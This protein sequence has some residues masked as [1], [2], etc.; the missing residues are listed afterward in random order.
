MGGLCEWGLFVCSLCEDLVL[1]PCSPSLGVKLKVNQLLL[2][3]TRLGVNPDIGSR[4]ENFALCLLPTNGHF[5][6]TN[7]TSFP[8][9][10]AS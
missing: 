8:V 1:E 5:N 6:Q 9:R 4:L 3:D 7:L 2:R 10:A